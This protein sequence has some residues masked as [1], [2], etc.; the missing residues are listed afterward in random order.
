MPI[1]AV[2]AQGVAGQI[3]LDPTYQAGL[4]DIG[5]F[6]HLILLY[7]LHLVQASSLLVTPFMDNQPHGIF[8]TRSPK[9]PNPIGLSVVRL[10][11]VEA[12]ILHI[13]DV[14][15]V[16]GTPLLD[17]KPYCPLSIAVRGQLAAGLNRTLNGFT[18]LELTSDSFDSFTREGNI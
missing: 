13:E 3:E 10:V 18:L 2:A 16:D 14:D 5:G 8:A 1:Q 6:S 7:Y 15:V 17:L 9:R 11:R 4:H 12:N